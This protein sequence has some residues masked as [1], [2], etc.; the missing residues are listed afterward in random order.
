MPWLASRKRGDSKGGR[1]PPWHTTLLAR[2]SV[3]YLLARLTGEAGC[4]AF[5]PRLH[6]QENGRGFCE[7]ERTKTL[8]VFGE[9]RQVYKPPSL[10]PRVETYIEM[11]YVSA[12]LRREEHHPRHPKSK[13]A[14]KHP[15]GLP[16]LTTAKRTRAGRS[17]LAL[18]APCTL[19]LTAPAGFATVQ[20]NT[21]LFIL[22]L[23]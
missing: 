17:R 14:G 13:E 2:C 9:R 1:G 11:R 19:T 8:S 10:V 18:K 7:R 15:W 21:K 20:T 23:L 16:A 3:L 4:G 6:R 5:A 22:S 12:N